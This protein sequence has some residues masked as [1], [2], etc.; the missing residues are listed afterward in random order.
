M[1][2]LFGKNIVRLNPQQAVNVAVPNDFDIFSGESASLNYDAETTAFT[3][4]AT[5]TGD[6]SN[7]TGVIAAIDDDGATGT[8]M[9]ND[10]T[11]TFQND[12]AITD[13]SGGAA[14]ADGVIRPHT[15]SWVRLHMVAATTVMTQGGVSVGGVVK[16][17][18]GTHSYPAGLEIPGDFTALQF[19]SGIVIAFKCD[20]TNV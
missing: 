18:A 6:T 7:A 8:L 9:L 5:L 4:G 10:I 15:G 16:Q 20:D 3:L 19:E 17:N 11:G 13:G 2:G 12:E 14:V 1:F